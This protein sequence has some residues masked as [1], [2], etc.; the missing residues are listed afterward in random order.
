MKSEGSREM[1]Y[2]EKCY[3]LAE[4]FLADE[5]KI[6]T[7]LNRKQ[8]AQEIQACIEDAIR[9]MQGHLR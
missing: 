8:L 4:Y 3:K 5:P 2:D 1:S 9:F 7:D 6:N